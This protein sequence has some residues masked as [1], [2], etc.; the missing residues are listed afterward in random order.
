MERD[1]IIFNLC[2]SKS[3][4]YVSK[5]CDCGCFDSI[6]GCKVFLQDHVGILSLFLLLPFTGQLSA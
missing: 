4:R 1:R 5:S 2:S 3:L 6:I